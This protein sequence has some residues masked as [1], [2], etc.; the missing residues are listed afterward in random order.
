[1]KT[2]GVTRYYVSRILPT[3]RGKNLI[4]YDVSPE[5]KIVIL[6]FLYEKTRN[7]ING[8]DDILCLARGMTYFSRVCEEGGGIYPACEILTGYEPEY[9]SF[10]NLP[11]VIA[12]V[13]E[14]FSGC[15]TG[16]TYWKSFLQFL[17]FTFV[18]PKSG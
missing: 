12:A 18:S 16:L 2:M 7:Y 4:Q 5:K 1:M 3:G 11:S 17:R 14:L 6:K 13:K 9:Q 8:G 10:G 15:A